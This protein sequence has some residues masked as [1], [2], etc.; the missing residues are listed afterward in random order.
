MICLTIKQKMDLKVLQIKVI[1][2]IKYPKIL[3]TI[4]KEKAKRLWR[5][6]A[7]LC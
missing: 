7:T 2:F 6:M 5:N 4:V 3:H 1:Y